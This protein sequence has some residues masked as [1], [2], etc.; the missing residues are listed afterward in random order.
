MYDVMPPVI[1]SAHFMEAQ[2]NH[3]VTSRLFQDNTS[4]MLLEKNGRASSTKRTKHMHIRYFYIADCI[5]RGVV[6]LE[7]C[8]T[9]DMLAD[10]FTKPLQGY[11]FYKLRALI[12]N[13][14]PSS[15]YYMCHRS[16]LKD[17]EMGNPEV[18]DS[19]VAVQA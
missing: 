15:K 14:D 18:A 7:H 19:A 11:L 8:P 10:F 4:A 6:K 13:I 9:A 5:A 1:W 17:P 2:T 16:V 3:D 12:M